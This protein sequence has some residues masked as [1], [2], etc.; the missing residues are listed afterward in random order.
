VSGAIIATACPV[1]RKNTE[2]I[3]VVN[4][5]CRGVRSWWLRIILKPAA[6]IRMS[7]SDAILIAISFSGKIPVSHLPNGAA[8]SEKA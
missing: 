1:N 6:F 2:A 3:K 8:F 7:V 5:D 4:S